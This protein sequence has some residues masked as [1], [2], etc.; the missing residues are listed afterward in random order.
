MSGFP[1]K[2]LLATDG[3]KDAALAA[4]AATDLSI[5]TGAEL[6]LVHVWKPLDATA[7]YPGEALAVDLDRLESRAADI[8]EAES[9]RITESGAKV[10]GEHLESGPVPDKILDVA[11]EIGADM[12]VVGSR[13]LGRVKRLLLGSVS[14]AVVHHARCPVLV[15]R[16]MWPPA[17]I[18]IGD[19]GSETSRAAGEL[20]AA[21]GGL[22]GARGTLLRAYQELP[23][24]NEEGRISDPRL[25]DDA[26]RRAER[27]LEERAGEL[28]NALGRR[29]RVEIAVG[30]PAAAILEK[31][32]EEV[33]VAVGSRGL[34][35]VG[36][37]RLGSVSTK[38]LRAAPGAILVQTPK[39]SR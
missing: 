19:D 18:V 33:L 17:R 27:A 9:G 12:I 22:F 32:D 13:G 36:R 21:I 26:L 34:G 1:R 35:P 16:G 2:V 11:E 7:G 30:D 37:F 39:T 20:A 15:L 31:A 29:P 10:A 14:E 24:T 38:V 23:E 4:R 3:S 28:E 6:H 5:Q 25:V 8:L